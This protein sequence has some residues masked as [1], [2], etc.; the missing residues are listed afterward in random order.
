M[1]NGYLHMEMNMVTEVKTETSNGDFLITAS[2]G[3]EHRHSRYR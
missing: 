3:L 1:K 2:L